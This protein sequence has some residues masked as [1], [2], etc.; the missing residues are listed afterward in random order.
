M[1]R[2][3]VCSL[4]AA[5]ALA[6]SACGPSGPR[7]ADADI[8]AYLAQTQP[9]YLRIGQVRTAFQAPASAS[10]LPA[11]SWR[12]HVD[13]VLRAQQDLFAPTPDSRGRRAGFD[14]AVAKVEQFRVARIAAVEQLGRQAGLIPEGASVP[15]PAVSVRLVTRKDQERADSVTLVAEPDGKSWKF[16]QADAQ[17]LDDEA[18]GAPLEALRSASPHIVFVAEGSQEEREARAREARFL[19]VLARALKL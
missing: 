15:E 10:K 13:F 14:L 4:L 19:D 7:P 9:Q 5:C 11:G 17:S 1:R 3:P 12:V 18:V 6:L 2:I 8:G 16:F